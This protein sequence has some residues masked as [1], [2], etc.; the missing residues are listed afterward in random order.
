MVLWDEDPNGATI[1]MLY[2][3]TSRSERANT[4]AVANILIHISFMVAALETP[5]SLPASSRLSEVDT[6]NVTKYHVLTSNEN[7]RTTTAIMMQ[8][9]Q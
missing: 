2:E 6:D 3:L 5:K 7:T 9:I 8:E 4:R 1:R